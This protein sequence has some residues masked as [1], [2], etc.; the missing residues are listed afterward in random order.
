MIIPWELFVPTLADGLSVNSKWQQV[1]S[2]V[3]DSSEYSDRSQ[4]CCNLDDLDS[5]SDFQFYQ[6]SF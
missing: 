3:Q 1:S 2:G 5:S 6:S 4:Q